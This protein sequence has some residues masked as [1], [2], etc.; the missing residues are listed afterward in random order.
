MKFKKMDTE[1]TI[2]PSKNGDTLMLP[3]TILHHR[4]KV[5]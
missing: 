5:P 1:E 4:A 2:I 3:H